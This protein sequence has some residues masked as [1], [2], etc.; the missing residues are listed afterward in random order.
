MNPH[1]FHPPHGGF[2]LFLTH[3]PPPHV[4]H[5][6]FFVLTA[7]RVAWGLFFFHSFPRALC[8]SHGAGLF[9]LIF[10]L[11]PPLHFAW[12]GFNSLF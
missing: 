12:I 9:S 5:G 2:L 6:R 11:F 7:L 3:L 8:I 4:L 1:P 10:S